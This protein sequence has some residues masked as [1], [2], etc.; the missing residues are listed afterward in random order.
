MVKKREDL[1]N[2]IIGIE[3]QM[4]QNVPNVGGKALCQ[5][6]PVTFKIMRFSQGMSWSEAAL[7]S[8][9]KDLKEAE[10]K[11]R[12]L[13]TEKYARMMRS[14][15]PSEYDQ[16]EH[17]LPP[18]NPEVFPLIDKILEIALPWQEELAERFPSILGRGR[19]LRASQDTPFAT[20]FE[21]YLRGELLTYSRRTLELY[22]RNLLKQKNE[23]ING[24]QIAL[25]HTVK[26]YG[27]SSLEEANKKLMAR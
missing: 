9:L 20:S 10:K 4:F 21:T 24:S 12:N 15:A 18:L 17:L 8:Y 1:I 26:Q 2:E 5:E 25:E 7:K 13:L 22:H 14:T 27:Y 16:I 23:N 11:E 3:W 6:D 19:P